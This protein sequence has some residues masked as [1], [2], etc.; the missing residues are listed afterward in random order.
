MRLKSV[1][2]GFA[3]LAL[4]YCGP[5]KP[6]VVPPVPTQVCLAPQVSPPGVYDITIGDKTVTTNADGYVYVLLDRGT[7]TIGIEAKGFRSY[8]G[9]YEANSLDCGTP[10]TLIKSQSRTSEQGPLGITNAAFVDVYGKP[11]IGRGITDF[12]LFAKYLDGQNLEQILNERVEHGRNYVR[13][14]GTLGGWGGW[15]KRYDNGVDDGKPVMPLSFL[16][17]QERG[18][19]Y[20]YQLS[21]FV[22]YLATFGM[23]IEFVIFADGQIVMPDY[24]ERRAHSDKVVQA[25]AGKWNVM[26]IE[27]ANEPF[28][29]VPGGD[30]EARDEAKRLKGRGAWIAAGDVSQLAW[31]EAIKPSGDYGTHHGERADDWTRRGRAL[32]ELRDATGMPW[33]SDEPMG[34]SPVNKPGSRSNVASDFLH[35]ATTTTL[36]GS[37]LFHCDSCA[38]SDMLGPKELELLDEFNFG[39]LWVP[40]EAQTWPYQRGS[41]CGD[42]PGVGDM[43]MAQWDLP[44]PQGSLRTFCKGNGSME[45]CNAN[46]PQPGW[47]A[48]ARAGWLV[49]DEPRR[50]LVRFAR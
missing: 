18:G 50:G 15:A 49:V 23:R 10:I 1:L 17:P 7:Y 8:Q 47:S 31:A 39:Q 16:F 33:I 40:R 19:D 43:P 11:W 6:V 24:N 14:F 44:H 2:L 25:I 41:N 42:C 20:Y 3:V 35:F 9:T 21:N 37:A 13:V 5:K 26:G 32:G 34:A 48:Q 28:K 12:L 4:A 22:D 29:N 36:F 38:F 46:R 27:Y 45:W 30:R